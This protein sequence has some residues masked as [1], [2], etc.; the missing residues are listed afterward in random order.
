MVQR[1]GGKTPEE[2]AETITY[3]ASSPDLAGITSKFFIDK[4]VV[5]SSPISYVH[6]NALRL[7]ESS[8]LMTQD[9]WRNLTSKSALKGKLTQFNFI[10]I[11]Y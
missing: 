2:G 7:W 9:K 3:L 5:K 8:E 4:K 6:E 1:L 11:K 10:P